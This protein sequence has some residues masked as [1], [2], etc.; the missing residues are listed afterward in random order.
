MAEVHRLYAGNIPFYI[1]KLN[2]S[3]FDYLRAYWNLVP[4]DNEAGLYIDLK[5]PYS[6]WE[7]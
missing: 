6:V 1:R 3:K 5:S 2:I 7:S 4:V